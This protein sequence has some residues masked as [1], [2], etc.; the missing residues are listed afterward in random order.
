M[1]S[2]WDCA[3]GLHEP[4][5]VDAIRAFVCATCGE[6]L[7]AHRRRAWA[8]GGELLFVAPYPVGAAVARNGG[9]A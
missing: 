7:C 4:A 6:P 1:T 2:R 5:W 3:K 8:L 9:M